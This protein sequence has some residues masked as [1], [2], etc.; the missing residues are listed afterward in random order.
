M[1]P[2]SNA[3]EILFVGDSA[4]AGGLRHH[5]DRLADVLQPLLPQGAEI[6]AVVDAG[7]TPALWRPAINWAGAPVPDYLGYLLGPVVDGHTFWGTD[8]TAID[9]SC[10][11]PANAAAHVALGGSH[12]EICLDTT[13]TLTSHITTPFFVGMDIN[14]PLA[15]ERYDKWGLLTPPDFWDAQFDQ[16]SLISTGAAGPVTP[17]VFGPKCNLHVRINSG[18]FFSQSVILAGGATGLSYHDLLVNWLTGAAPATEIQVDSTAG[19]FYTNSN[20][21]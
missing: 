1:P 13:F 2:L 6:N 7:F 3:E 4:G 8:P 17:G 15:R 21:P 9:S 10:Q 16:L 5:I 19:P 14:D 18:R 11:N 20:C 12:P